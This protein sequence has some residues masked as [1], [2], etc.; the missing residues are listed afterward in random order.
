MP[1]AE[2]QVR[3][4]PSD[5]VLADVVVPWVRTARAGG[6]GGGM[7]RCG[8]VCGVFFFFLFEGVYGGG[9]G[10]RGEGKKERRKG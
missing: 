1:V 3:F 8:V 9:L 2:E 5:D 7:G 4:G 6:G 10:Y